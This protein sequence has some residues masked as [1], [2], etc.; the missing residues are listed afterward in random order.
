VGNGSGSGWQVVKVSGF[1]AWRSV[2]DGSEWWFLVIAGSG[3]RCSTRLLGGS[4]WFW[5]L[6]M[7]CGGSWWLQVVLGGSMW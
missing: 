1:C 2:V 6:A 3:S 5:C 4:E 7:V